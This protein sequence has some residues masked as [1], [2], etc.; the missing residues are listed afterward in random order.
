M[1]PR[2]QAI[3]RAIARLLGFAGGATSAVAGQPAPTTDPPAQIRVQP[4]DVGELACAIDHTMSGGV[5]EIRG[6]VTS[7]T[8]GT[9]TYRLI[10]R[11]SGTAG[12]S[13]LSQGGKVVLEPNAR[14]GLGAI[15]LSVEAGARYE[16]HLSVELGEKRKECHISGETDLKL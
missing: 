16:A 7:S 12:T 1:M 14:V 10:V 2:M 15:N 13:N 8:G 11:K 9:A 4:A 3:M 6:A 5:T